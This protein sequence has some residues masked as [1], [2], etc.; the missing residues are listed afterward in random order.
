MTANIGGG[1]GAEEII[2]MSLCPSLLEWA[3]A[4]HRVLTTETARAWYNTLTLYCNS[5]FRGIP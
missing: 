3:I 2:K 4:G 5:L 1:T